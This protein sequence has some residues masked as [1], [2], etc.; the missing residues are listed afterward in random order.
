MEK[1]KFLTIYCEKRGTIEDEFIFVL[2]TNGFSI[3]SLYEFSEVH[4]HRR[5]K[6]M[7]K[8]EVEMGAVKNNSPHLWR[9]LKELG[10]RGIPL[11][12]SLYWAIFQPGYLITFG[13]LFFCFESVTRLLNTVYSLSSS[14]V[15]VF[16]LHVQS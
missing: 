10:H 8:Q 13:A 5:K 7:W 6:H 4:K 12:S 1:G 15:G 14:N 9:R 16:F 3:S 2:L 11:L